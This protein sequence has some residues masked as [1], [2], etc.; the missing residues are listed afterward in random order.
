[1]HRVANGMVPNGCLFL[2]CI[3]YSVI[4]SCRIHTIQSQ[5]THLTHPTSTFPRPRSIASS[6]TLRFLS[7]N[8]WFSRVHSTL[9]LFVPSALA[10][11][12]ASQFPSSHGSR[13]KLSH[14]FTW[15]DMK[16][17]SRNAQGGKWYG[18]KWMFVLEL[19]SI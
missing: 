2:N 7:Y 18:A 15:I 13:A 6:T 16:T 5:V 10:L 1:M 8:C 14:H 11:A 19:Y 4:E 9:Y 3:P 17:S 12:C